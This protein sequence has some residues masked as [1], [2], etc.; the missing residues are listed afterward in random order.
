MPFE[1]CTQ[2]P[3]TLNS[4]FPGK[5]SR[6][7]PFPKSREY[8]SRDFE[9]SLTAIT[10]IASLTSITR[11]VPALCTLQLALERL[12]NLERSSASQL[13]N[14]VTEEEGRIFGSNMRSPSQ[15]ARGRVRFPQ[16]CSEGLVPSRIREM[17][18][19]HPHNAELRECQE[20]AHF[21]HRIPRPS[22]MVEFSPDPGML[23]DGSRILRL[24]GTFSMITG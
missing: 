8:H 5:G 2:A 10:T 17:F 22:I 12:K 23:G 19:F 20:E 24:R 14:S 21:P 7:G 4:T 9:M 3:P 15:K 6:S 11:C 16:R 1:I 18:S 13:R